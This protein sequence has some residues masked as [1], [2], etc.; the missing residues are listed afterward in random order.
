MVI[1][2]SLLVAAVA[3][4]RLRLSP[5]DWNYRPLM[6]AGS[7]VVVAASLGVL[8]RR[9]LW[10]LIG[11]MIGVAPVLWRF[12]DSISSAIPF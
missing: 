4:S 6:L 2:A 7:G 12:K 5:F 3:I 8:L 9:T 10:L 11:A 1:A